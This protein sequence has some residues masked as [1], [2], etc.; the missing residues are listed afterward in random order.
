MTLLA[1]VTSPPA[2]YHGCSTWN[3]FWEEKFTPVNMKSCVRINVRKHK[4]I[5]NGEKYII[6][7]ISSKLDFL[8]KRE[9]TSSES[10]DFM[11]IS[12]KGLTTS[13]DISTKSSNN[14]QKAR[15]AITDIANQDFRKLLKKFNNL[16]YIGYKSK[17]VHNEPSEAYLFL[18][19]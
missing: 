7:D 18:I 3:N 11:G 16:P 4:E 1:V 8:D 19:K 6:L 2:I 17:Q 14:K 10:K 15:F 9:V 5:N 13:L 12:G